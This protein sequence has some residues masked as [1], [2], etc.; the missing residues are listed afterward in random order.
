MRIKITCAWALMLALLLQFP[1]LAY[2][3]REDIMSESE[4]SAYSLLDKDILSDLHNPS[5]LDREYP[6]TQCI[7]W[8]LA[9]KAFVFEPRQFI[10]ALQAGT[11]E[12]D[13]LKNATAVWKVPVYEDENGYGYAI[14][15]T[16]DDNPGYVTVSAD[17]N[18]L[19]QAAYLF[20]DTQVP[21]E[22]DS[23]HA[24]VYIVSVPEYDV[25]FI[26]IISGETEL[27][28]P[29]STCPEWLRLNNGEEYSAEDVLAALSSYHSSLSWPA[30]GGDH[31]NN[32]RLI[33]VSIFVLVL[34]GCICAFFARRKIKSRT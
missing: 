31:A 33:T 4:R 34:G 16:N 24:S 15:G 30:S 12:E 23:G 28:I 5:I 22:S 8:S 1:V 26:T 32:T 25:D 27:F 21:V 19:N 10:R 14:V 18:A 9:R 2:D 17:A 13:I 7:D 11:L 20:M 3:F 29:Y 6:Y